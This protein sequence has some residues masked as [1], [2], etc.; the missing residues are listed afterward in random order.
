VSG[1]RISSLPQFLR[2]VWSAGPA[3]APIPLTLSRGRES[4]H[5]NVQ[6]ASRED[7]LKKPLRH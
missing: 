3:G 6:S 1:Q 5:V 2:G 7:F 4:L